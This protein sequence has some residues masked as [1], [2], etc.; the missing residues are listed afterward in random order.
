[1]N[2]A[3]F[4]VHRR[5]VSWRRPPVAAKKDDWLDVVEA[6]ILYFGVTLTPLL[7]AILLY[8]SGVIT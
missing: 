5:R 2:T 1:M 3:L 8:E 7:V 6:A 4:R